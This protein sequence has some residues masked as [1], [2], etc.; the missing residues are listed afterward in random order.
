M[1]LDTSAQALSNTKEAVSSEKLM[2]I[3][4]LCN[5]LLGLGLGSMTSY[6]RTL[7]HA[8]LD[9]L[10]PFPKRCVFVGGKGVLVGCI[11]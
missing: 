7:R 10:S 2:C 4:L 5:I 11:R 1:R 3:K 6:K 9:T 8:E